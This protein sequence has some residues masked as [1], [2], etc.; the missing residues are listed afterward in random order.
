MNKIREIRD[1]QRQ[2]ARKRTSTA[3]MATLPAMACAL[4][5]RS[6]MENPDT[7]RKEVLGKEAA[8]S[9]TRAFT[10]FLELIDGGL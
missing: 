8:V 10:L 2:V 6:G 7:A 5:M 1:R 9:D 4:E 3:G